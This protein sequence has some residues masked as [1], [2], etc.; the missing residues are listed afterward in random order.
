[1]R[2]ASFGWT[3]LLVFALAMGISPA[4]DA[5]WSVTPA[6][7]TAWSA[8]LPLTIY[9][10]GHEPIRIERPR[11]ETRPLYESPYYAIRVDNGRWGFEL[12]HHKLY[13]ATAHPE[14][15]Q[16][17]I[18]HGYNLVLIERLVSRPPVTLVYGAGPVVTHPE[19]IVRGLELSDP[20][21]AE[22]SLTGYYL[23]GAALHAGAAYRRPLARRLAVVA[24]AKLTAAWATVPV[25]NGHADVPNLAVHGIV[26][27]QAS[28]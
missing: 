9:Q 10:Q 23:S 20:P 7:G 26:G 14:V 21:H 27:L 11:W 1:M 5:K 15:Q 18:S 12:I 19:T 25:A 4:A 2:R 17:W 6:M 3:A 8:P 28:W 16:F 24:E 22:I 13:L